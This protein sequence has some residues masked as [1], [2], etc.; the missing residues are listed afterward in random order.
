MENIETK[1]KTS[2]DRSTID[3]L[4][5]GDYEKALKENAL[6]V[7]AE[8]EAR[9]QRLTEIAENNPDLSSDDVAA[10]EKYPNLS[11]HAAR[12]AYQYGMPKD[13]TEVDASKK[14]SEGLEAFKNGG[15]DYMKAKFEEE[16]AKDKER[17]AVS[18]DIGNVATGQAVEVKR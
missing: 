18:F 9:H 6:V 13:V 3:F 2:D 5:S 4:V 15:G 12:L 7:E 11:I 17:L 10:K 14:F 8:T 16:A 1:T